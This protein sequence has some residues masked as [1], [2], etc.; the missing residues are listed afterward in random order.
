MSTQLGFVDSSFAMT[1]LDDEGGNVGYRRPWRPL[2]T[3]FT[4]VLHVLNRHLP[5][6]VGYISD[7]H[8]YPPYIFRF[9]YCDIILGSARLGVVH[10][11]T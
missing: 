7:G 6:H 4:G 11:R 10:K 9:M 5:E 3:T 1:R 8:H 2:I